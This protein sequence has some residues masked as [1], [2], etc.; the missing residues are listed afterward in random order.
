M[1]KL[2]Q[3]SL[4]KTCA[5]LLLL[6]FL[7]QAWSLWHAPAAWYPAAV[8]ARLALGETVLLGQRELAAPQADRNHIALHRDSGGNWWLRNLSPAKQVLL[9]TAD[10]ERQMGSVAPQAGQQF[11]VGAA[12]FEV[13]ASDAGGISFRRG[14]QRWRYDGAV[15]Y[16]DGQAQAACADARPA[17]RALMLWNRVMPDWLTVARP[18]VFGGNI[19]CGNRLGLADITPGAALLARADGQLRLSAGN[20]DG[21]RASLLLMRDGVAID[22]RRQEQ[23]LTNVSAMVVGHTRFLLVPQPGQLTMLPGRRVSLFSAPDSP[24]PAQVSWQWRAREVWHGPGQKTAVGRPVHRT[25]GAAAGRQRT[26]RRRLAGA[27]RGAVRRRGAGQRHH[28]AGDAARRPGAQ[29]RLFDVPGR[30]RAGVV[31]AAAGPLAIG[32]RRRPA[33]AVGRLA[34]AAGNGPGRHGIVVAALLP[35]KRGTAGDRLR[36]RRLVALVAPVRRHCAAAA[37]HRM[38]AV[39]AGG[40]GAGRAGDASAVGR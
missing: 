17:S 38:G 28:R 34:G 21:E 25:A 18:L 31:A 12:R 2:S 27:R 8:T 29:R 13:T 16:R 24:L 39:A 5:A 7:M 10:G 40:A 20:P 19:H 37:R 9:Q 23:S 4:F 1:K 36:R 35:E 3:P 30:R 15:L 32:R 11:Q 33:V 26:A 6:F 14:A 22:V